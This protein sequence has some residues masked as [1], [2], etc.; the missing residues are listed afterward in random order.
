MDTVNKDNGELSAIEVKTT[1]IQSETNGDLKAHEDPVVLLIDQLTWLVT[2][3]QKS[4]EQRDQE[5]NKL[6]HLFIQ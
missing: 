5:L 1:Q 3:S 6:L 4:P 2:V